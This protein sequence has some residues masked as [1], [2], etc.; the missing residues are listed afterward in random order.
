M[1][2]SLSTTASMSYQEDDDADSVKSFSSSVSVCSSSVSQCDH[3]SFARN[4]TTFSG[5]SK[6]YI[7]HCS[8]Q[9]TEADDY[10]TPTQ[11]TA[12]TIRKLRVNTYIFIL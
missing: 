4:G 1:Q 10:L 5:R 11:R 12:R 2:Q 7:L 6:R 9:F 8:P 3:T